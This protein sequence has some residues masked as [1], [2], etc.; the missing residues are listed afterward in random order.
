MGNQTM[1]LCKFA[2]PHAQVHTRVDTYKTS[3]CSPN[4]KMMNDP[5]TNICILKYYNYITP[6]KYLNF[7][8]YCFQLD[9]LYLFF[10][11]TMV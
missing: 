5:S 4:K 7:T 2:L 1:Q 10:I 3:E 9:L 11:Y 8:A 6:K